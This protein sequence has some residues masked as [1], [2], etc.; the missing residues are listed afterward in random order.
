[1]PGMNVFSLPSFDEAQRDFRLRL[2][3]PP[4]LLV[5]SSTRLA[6]LSSVAA[7]PKREARLFV[8]PAMTSIEKYLSALPSRLDSF[9]FECMLFPLPVFIDSVKFLFLSKSRAFAAAI[10]RA[11]AFGP[12]EDPADD[13]VLNKLLKSVLI[14]SDCC[15]MECWIEWTVC[16]WFPM[17]VS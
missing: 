17:L 5:S 3:S 8:I 11:E 12:A 13:E 1:M 16:G 9:P 6:L 4:L 10:A 15:S 7:K 14:G 2:R